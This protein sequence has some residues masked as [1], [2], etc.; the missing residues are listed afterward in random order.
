MKKVAA[1]N[2]VNI[3]PRVGFQTCNNILDK[4]GCSTSQKVAIL[5]ITDTKFLTYQKDNETPLLTND[6]LERLSYILNIHLAL[7][8]IFSNPENI[9]NFMSLKNNNAYF[10][11]RTPIS[12]IETGELVVLSEVASRLNSI[13]SH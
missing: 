5:G 13:G 7:K 8:T 9:D 2:S 1:R 6:Q 4:W 12:L 10:N 3:D 11:G